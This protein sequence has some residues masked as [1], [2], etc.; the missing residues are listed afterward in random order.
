MPYFL[1]M[2]NVR[3]PDAQTCGIH[4][5][6]TQRSKEM[7]GCPVMINLSTRWCVFPPT[8][9]THVLK[10]VRHGYGF[11]VIR[12]SQNHSSTV[13][14]PELSNNNSSSIFL[15]EDSDKALRD[16]LALFLPKFK[17]IVYSQASMLVH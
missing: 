3:V 13:S 17:T 5:A 11:E 2:K 6:R 15:P 12:H 4:P 16:G 7:D 10:M 14:G 9:E 8:P 1:N